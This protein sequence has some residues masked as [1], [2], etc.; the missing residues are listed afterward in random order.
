MKGE[1]NMLGRIKFWAVVICAF[2]FVAIIT[3]YL[4]SLLQLLG[5][6][7]LSDT[8]TLDGFTGLIGA[9]IGSAVTVIVLV[10]TMRFEKNQI[11]Y[12]LKRNI[13]K[14]R[15]D[16]V[17]NEIA[18][19]VLN[20]KPEQIDCV[21]QQLLRENEKNKINNDAD[22]ENEESQ[23]NRIVKELNDTKR[24]YNS[25]LLSIQAN[26]DRLSLLLTIDE[27]K[28]LNSKI[29]EFNELIST[30]RELF[31]ILICCHELGC[32]G[33]FLPP[34]HPKIQ[35]LAKSLAQWCSKFKNDVIDEYNSTHGKT[36]DFFILMEKGEICNFN[37]MMTIMRFAYTALLSEDIMLS[38][39][40][41]LTSSC[42][43]FISEEEHR[44]ILEN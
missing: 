34:S 1:I 29:P 39:Y 6:S 24:I 22:M 18:N 4:P 26:A 16:F 8:L 15:F 11:D 37:Q 42:Q 32:Y 31:N 3:I 38:S 23:K 21:I 14:E 12:E 33:G 9:I 40:R 41:S 28:K 30:Y 36:D 43:K 19:A 17:R 25:V 2:V 7:W 20:I 5:I 27:Y 35:E 13:E 44:I 10:E